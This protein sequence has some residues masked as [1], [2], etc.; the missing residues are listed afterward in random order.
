MKTEISETLRW[1]DKAR[2]YAAA[3]REGDAVKIGDKWHEVKRY[4]ASITSTVFAESNPYNLNYDIEG[5]GRYEGI[6]KGFLK[7]RVDSPYEIVRPKDYEVQTGDKIVW[8]GETI[9]QGDR[10]E[11]TF[12]KTYEVFVSEDGSLIYKNDMTI[13]LLA[14]YLKEK[15]SMWGVI[16]LY[17]NVEQKKGMD[18]IND[19]DEHFGKAEAFKVGD[20]VKVNGTDSRFDGCIDKVYNVHETRDDLCYFTTFEDGDACWV[21]ADDLELVGERS[22]NEKTELSNETECSRKFKVGDI[23]EVVN[24]EDKHFISQ[25]GVVMYVDYCDNKLPYDV[26]FSEDSS[27]FNSVSLRKVGESF[28][29]NAPIANTPKVE[30]VTKIKTIQ[31]G[32]SHWESF[33]ERVNAFMH[34][35]DVIDVSHSFVTDIRGLEN[36]IAVITYRYNKTEEE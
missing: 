13:M 21:C 24:E 4:T 22:I 18:G 32:V 12:G 17:E 3:F 34:D 6:A 30:Y 14:S 5:K 31:E 26:E 8:L 20:M 7:S 10:S 2:A 11:F 1:S 23:V 29:A 25:T 9:M 35:K 19:I 28:I 15:N 27:W 33:D 16:P 36:I